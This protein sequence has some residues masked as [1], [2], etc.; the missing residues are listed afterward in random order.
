M[1]NARV[2]K[3]VL[4][5]PSPIIM[6]TKIEFAAY[7][8]HGHETQWVSQHHSSKSAGVTDLRSQE[9]LEQVARTIVGKQ[10]HI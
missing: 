8:S 7:V 5:G 6:L 1:Q 3:G 4:T 2:K 9:G 10:V